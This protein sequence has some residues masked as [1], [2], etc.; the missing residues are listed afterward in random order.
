M[1]IRPIRWITSFNL[2][3]IL[4]TV[5]LKKDLHATILTVQYLFHLGRG[6]VHVLYMYWSDREYTLGEWG[7]VK[8]KNI[9][10][11]TTCHNVTTPTKATLSN[12][13]QIYKS[14]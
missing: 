7:N 2:H 10:R 3:T 6:I 4:R 1:A 14:R 12:Y 9:I 13:L 8:D 5:R 11:K